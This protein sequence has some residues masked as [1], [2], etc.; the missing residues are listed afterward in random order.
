MEELNL[1][2]LEKKINYTFHNKELL[3]RALSHKSYS[4]EKGL[5][6]NYE[7]L[8]FLGDSVISLIV[9][10][11]LIKRFPE[12][13]EGEL[14]SIRAFLVSENSL[15]KLAREI[16]LGKFILLG[17]GEKKTGGTEKESIL[18]DVFEAIFGA[19][20]LDSD[21]ETA[22]KVFRKTFIK[23]MWEIF[24]SRKVHK[25]FKSQLQEFTQRKLKVKPKYEIEKEKGPEHEK[26]FIVKC[27]VMDKTVVASGKS[28]KDAQQKAAKKM[29]EVLGVIND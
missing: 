4:F 14:S 21:F 9:S 26:E 5:K 13:S 8:E 28:K 18:C 25:D 12:K 19:I 6:E 29:L 24:N 16:E 22:K 7:V 27:T 15:A 1:L 3:R 10:E 17:K 20:Y 11:I 23:S 2:E